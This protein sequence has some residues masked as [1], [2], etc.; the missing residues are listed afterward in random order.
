[1]GAV[2][3]NTYFISDVH[4]GHS[5]IL[6]YHPKRRE[7]AGITLKELQTNK[8]EAVRKHDEWLINLWNNTIKK[9]DVVYFLGDFSWYN[10]ADTEKLLGKLHGKKFLIRGNHDKPL[11]G[12][13][14]YFEWVGDIKEAKFNHDE[15]DFID[16]N[17]TFC[18]EM[19]HY[20]MLTWNR[21]PHGT[22]HAHG[23]CH[24]S[25]TPLNNESGELR[26]DVGLDADLSG[27]NFISLENLYN[28]FKNIVTV[29]GCS[30]FLEYNEKL[31]EKQGFRS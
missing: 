16:P 17:E 27:Y 29:N 25:I 9:N 8:K 3:N 22:V 24:N 1:M 4:F 21:R 20:P 26:V 2:K 15:Y 23:H 5:G 13:E 7:L 31:M 30:S 11:Q 10:K 19:C 18:V 6:Y 12:L 14:R 28:Y